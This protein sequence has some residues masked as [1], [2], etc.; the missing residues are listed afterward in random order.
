MRIDLRVPVGLPVPEVAEF[1][2][3]CEDAGLDG[4][5]VHDHPHS[6]RD[7]YV[8]LA[9]AAARTRRLRL[10]PATSSPV[11]RHPL[12]LASLA[13]SLEEVAPGRVALTVAPGFL[14]V[15]SIGEP[16]APV[17]VMR[18]AVLTIRRLLGG[19]AV[20][21]GAATTRLRHPSP[22][23]TPV[24]LLAAGPR[25]VEL[26]G[27]VADGALLLVGLDG[28]AIARARRH[29]RDGARRAGRSLGGFPVAFVVPLG[30]ADTLAEARRWPQRWCAPD[31]PFL[32]Y[33]SASNLYWLREA[34][35]DLPGGASPASIGDA[36]AA[37]VCEA[38]GLFGPAEHCA[39]RLLRARDE[40]G[41]EHVFLFPAHTRDGS[42]EMPAAE[43]EAVRRVIRPRVR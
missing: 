42:Y 41:V 37:R 38:F 20:S 26:A 5:G 15:R 18:E 13:H 36:L 19:E 43:V 3:R 35:L 12:L 4:V 22:A 14:S 40:A 9:L 8:T 33:P 6:G 30:L 23:P 7:A 39:E 28:R 25:M 31:Q 1:I 29:L 11:V 32:A 21:L 24:Y 17:A 27:E 16:R 34:G 10:Y 2:A